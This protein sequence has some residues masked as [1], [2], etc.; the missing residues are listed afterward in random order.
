MRIVDQNGK[1]LSQDEINAL[2]DA[3][4]KERLLQNQIDASAVGDEQYEE[5]RKQ[6]SQQLQKQMIVTRL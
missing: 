3:R 4:I 6:I 5:L 1:A 2:I